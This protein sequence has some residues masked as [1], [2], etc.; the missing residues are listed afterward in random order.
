M[1]WT[2]CPQRPRWSGRSRQ[3]SPGRSTFSTRR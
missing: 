1:R 3:W 2:R